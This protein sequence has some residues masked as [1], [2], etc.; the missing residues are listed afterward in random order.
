LRQN[1]ARYSHGGVH[2]R[3]RVTP[4][5]P[6][7]EISSLYQAAD[8]SLSLAVKVTAAP[9]KGKANSAV[10]E[11]LAKALKVPKS[12]FSIVSGETNR[13]KVVFV[14]GDLAPLEASIAALLVKL[15][16]EGS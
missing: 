16:V 14:A 3:V 10:V 4:K 13:N 1:F 2:L 5:S 11:V 12:R 8:G 6:R 15:K 9:D 7:N